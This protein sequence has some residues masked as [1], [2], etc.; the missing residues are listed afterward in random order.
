MQST[1]WR[2][3]EVRRFFVS[4]SVRKAGSGPRHHS[5][6]T[7]HRPGSQ[8]FN[9]PTS[10]CFNKHNLTIAVNAQHWKILKLFSP[11][12]HNEQYHQEDLFHCHY[13]RKTPSPSPRQKK[14]KILNGCCSIFCLHPLTAGFPPIREFRENFEDFFQSGKS[15][16][17]GFSAKIREKNFK[18]GNFFPNHF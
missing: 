5:C 14:R 10:K 3:W 12:V 6:W 2:G 11:R 4:I 7:H 9:K 13:F 16:K 17:N 1:S 18:S 15:G 8:C